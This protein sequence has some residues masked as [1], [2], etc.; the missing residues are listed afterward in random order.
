MH[1]VHGVKPDPPGNTTRDALLALPL[2]EHR[3]AGVD[4]VECA[5][6][7]YRCQLT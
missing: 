1:R 4:L 5:M 3:R 6:D 2:Q 7:L